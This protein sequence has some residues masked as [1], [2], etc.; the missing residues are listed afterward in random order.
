[1]SRLYLRLPLNATVLSFYRYVS[2]LVFKG[3]GSFYSKWYFTGKNTTYHGSTSL[4]ETGPKI[5][6]GGVQRAIEGVRK[7]VFVPQHLEVVDQKSD[8]FD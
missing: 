8:S 6:V 4:Y 2:F 5:A 1:M 7:A 3:A